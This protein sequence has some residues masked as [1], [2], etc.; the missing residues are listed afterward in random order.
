MIE[1]KDLRDW[2]FRGLMFESEAE[3][4][5]SAGIQV[6]ADVSRTEREL[7]QET[8]A[9][10]GVDVRGEA[11]RMARLY[12]LLYCFE[13]SVRELI[14]D[15]LRERHGDHWWTTK[16]PRKV[17]EFAAAR[18]KDAVDNSWLE[19]MT[20]DPLSFVQFGHLSDIIIASWDD[21]SDLITSQHWLKQRLEELERARNY[22]A[23]NR[24]L[25]PAEF[26]RIEMYV[27]DWNRMVGL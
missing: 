24:Y 7:Q 25:L 23:H 17:Q 19:G 1:T 18:Q 26:Q 22:I 15:R 9:P 3:K 5:R 12:A 16:V 10:F 2:L 14:T 13:N 6:G 8:L 11:M 21:F 4:F 20:K 27:N